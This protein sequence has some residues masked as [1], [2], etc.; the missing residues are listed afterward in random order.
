MR[1]SLYLQPFIEQNAKIHVLDTDYDMNV[2][3][4]ILGYLYGM[5]LNLDRNGTMKFFL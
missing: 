1:Q 4:Q 3:E 5:N 2:F